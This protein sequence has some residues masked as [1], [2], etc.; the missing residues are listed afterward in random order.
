MSK[1]IVLAG[2]FLAAFAA[3]SGRAAAGIF[4]EEEA[5]KLNKSSKGAFS[6][7]EAALLNKKPQSSSGNSFTGTAGIELSG[8]Y[9]KLSDDTFKEYKETYCATSQCKS[10]QSSI[11]AGVAV[12]FEAGSKIK[13][14]GSLGY[15]I[16]PSGNYKRIRPTSTRTFEN[17]AYSVPAALYAKMRQSDKV[18]LFAGVGVDYIKAKVQHKFVSTVTAYKVDYTDSKLVPGVSIGAEIFPA[19]KMS[20][21]FGLKYMFSG[22]INGFEDKDGNKLSDIYTFDYNFSGLRI[23]AAARYYF[24]S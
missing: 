23:N 4:S 8:A 14:G 11:G 5:A 17:S 24:G 20:V 9:W 3:L 22:K 15:N 13:F 21:L 16:L 2:L 1:K 7:E 19:G 6:D 18:N 10:D 12:F